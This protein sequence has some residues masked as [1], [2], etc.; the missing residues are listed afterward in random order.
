MQRGGS[1]FFPSL[2]N[3]CRSPAGCLGCETC[4]SLFWHSYSTGPFGL[5]VEEP[6]L[7]QPILFWDATRGTSLP[8]RCTPPCIFQPS[9]SLVHWRRPLE[10][11]ASSRLGS[12]VRGGGGGLNFSELS[13]VCESTVLVFGTGVRTAKYHYT[14]LS[15]RG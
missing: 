13:L 3:C 7:L 8:G 2:A 5:M 14:I 9:K 1:N 6:L 4:V 15:S 11:F 12:K 10:G